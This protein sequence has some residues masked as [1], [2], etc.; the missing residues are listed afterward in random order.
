MIKTILALIGLL[1]VAYWLLAAKPA[2]CDDCY[3]TGQ[4]CYGQFECGEYCS[5][6]QPDGHG[7]R[8]FCS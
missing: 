1:T 3:L 6:F 7:S 8:G 2:E 4:A 5:C